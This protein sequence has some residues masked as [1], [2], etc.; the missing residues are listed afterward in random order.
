M[1]YDVEIPAYHR[2][3]VRAFSAEEAVKAAESFFETLTNQVAYPSPPLAG[4]Y[5]ASI[6]ETE[7]LSLSEGEDNSPDVYRLDNA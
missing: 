2:V 6:V 5:S 3:Q 4:S 1:L 7:I